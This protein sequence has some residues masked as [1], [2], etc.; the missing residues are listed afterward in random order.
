MLENDE[1]REQAACKGYTVNDFFPVK[2]GRHN[3][4]KVYSLIELCDSCPVNAECLYTAVWT[5]SIGI[6]GRTTFRQRKV[7]IS[8]YLESN[9]Y[10]VTLQKCRE[11]ISHLKDRNILP[12][13]KSVEKEN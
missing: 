11:Y 3:S 13:R 5:D 7:F 12:N 9:R 1:W 6:W 4:K 10:T 2:I 8:K